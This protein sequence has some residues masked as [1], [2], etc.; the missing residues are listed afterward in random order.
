MKKKQKFGSKLPKNPPRSCGTV[1]PQRDFHPRI[2]N[3]PLFIEVSAHFCSR[4]YAHGC[5][6]SYTRVIC[7]KLDRLAVRNAAALL[8]THPSKTNP[9]KAK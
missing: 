9:F 7:P 1:I 3:T 5:A 4:M 6:R 8:V 2:R